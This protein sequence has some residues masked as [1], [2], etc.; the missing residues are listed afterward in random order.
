[1]ISCRS[2]QMLK[3]FWQTCSFLLLLLFPC[4]ATGISLHGTQ[5]SPANGPL[6]PGA[7]ITS[8][9]SGEGKLSWDQEKTLSFRQSLIGTLTKHGLS[10]S[11]GNFI[12][13]IHH[14]PTPLRLNIVPAEILLQTCTFHLLVKPEKQALLILSGKAK[15]AMTQPTTKTILLEAGE[16]ISWKRGTPRMIG[17]RFTA[18]TAREPLL[19]FSDSFPMEVTVVQAGSIRLLPGEK[20][21]PPDSIV[22]Q[23]ARV[24]T[25]SDQG[26]TLKVG[27][28]SDVLLAPDSEL[29]LRKNGI[30]ILQGSAMIRH[31]GNVRPLS[32]LGYQRVDLLPNSV[33]ETARTKDVLLLRVQHGKAHTPTGNKDFQAGETFQVDQEGSRAIDFFPDGV[34]WTTATPRDSTTQNQGNTS[35]PGNHPAEEPTGQDLPSSDPDEDPESVDLQEFL[36]DF[37][38]D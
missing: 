11:K 3:P 31:G 38:D 29:V 7:T 25:S 6:T 20:I 30:E 37:A 12:G 2:S 33:C 15:V 17:W 22:P 8:T 32:L 10:I 27:L 18:N 24:S 26:A 1:M 28:Q 35:S 16:G 14:A 23:G 13:R 21:L 9:P 4:T 5:T 19:S 36:Q 34:N